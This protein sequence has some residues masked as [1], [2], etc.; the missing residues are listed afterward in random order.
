MTCTSG[1]RAIVWR[2]HPSRGATGSECAKHCVGRV[3]VQVTT[4]FHAFG[5]LCWEFA[6]DPIPCPKNPQGCHFTAF[7]DY[8]LK[9]LPPEEDVLELDAIKT[10]EVE[11][12]F[13]MAFPGVGNVRVYRIK[14]G[15]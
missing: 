8:E 15:P 5:G 2:V 9:P 6:G 13:T 1:D 10:V 3:I 12:S 14:G 4:P 11:K 7:Y